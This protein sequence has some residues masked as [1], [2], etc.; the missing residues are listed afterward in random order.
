MSAAAPGANSPQCPIHPAGVLRGGLDPD[1]EVTR[2]PWSTVNGK[3]GALPAG[4]EEVLA[5][6]GLEPEAWLETIRTFHR[7]FSS[8]WSVTC[9]ASR[10]TAS[11]HGA[12]PR[13]G[14]RLGGKALQARG[15]ALFRLTPRSQFSNDACLKDSLERGNELGLRLKADDFSW[16]HRSARAR[17]VSRFLFSILFPMRPDVL[18]CPDCGGRLR[19]LATIEERGVVE[20]ILRHLGLPVDLPQPS[21]ARTQEWLP[22]VRT[23][24]DYYEDEAGAYWSH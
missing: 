17:G 24:A 13:E 2:R 18:A 8:P 12:A 3:R 16:L 19:L 11:G 7:R 14:Q 10:R 1:V 15:Q 21:A 6:L 22:G 9:T 23:V 4:S 20:K 5:R